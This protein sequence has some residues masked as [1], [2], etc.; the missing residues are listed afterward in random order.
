[1][2]IEI[3]ITGNH[4]T[5][6]IAEVQT[7]ATVFGLIGTAS[8]PKVIVYG[9][10]KTATSIKD[11]AETISA[12]SQETAPASTDK[13]LTRKEQDEAVKYMINQKEKDDRFEKLTKGRQEEVEAALA[14]AAEPADEKKADA[15]L[16][17]MFA[18]DAAEPAKVVSRDDVSA[19]MAKIG[20]DKDGNPIQDKLLKIRAI[21]VENIPEGNEPKVK[22]IPEDKLATVYSLIEKIGV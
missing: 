1:M 13:P 22:N 6:I 17:D 4:A 14:K 19:M 12:P 21:L 10:D 18:D 9:T 5:D 2:P 15:D 11:V 7:L 3:K 16:D 20:K 8:E